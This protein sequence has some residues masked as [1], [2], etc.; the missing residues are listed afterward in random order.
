M[1]PLESRAWLTLWGM[2]PAYAVYFGIEAA[3]PAWFTTMTALFVALAAAACTHALVY[4]AGLFWFKSQERGQGLLADERD[5]AIDA[6]ATRAAYI[7]LL[8]GTIIAGMMMPFGKTG[9][10]IVNAALLAIVLAETTR[11]ALVVRGYRSEAR[12]AH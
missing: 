8:T 2:C 5:R 12:L 6:R 10:Q 9:W 1:S 11:N 4:L 3:F 7:V